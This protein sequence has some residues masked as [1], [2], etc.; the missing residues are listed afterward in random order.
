MEKEQKEG[1]G[2]IVYSAEALRNRFQTN[3]KNKSGRISTTPEIETCAVSD[4]QALIDA[5]KVGYSQQAVVEFTNF[6]QAVKNGTGAENDLSSKNPPL[7][8]TAAVREF[9]EEPEEDSNSLG[10]Y[11]LDKRLLIKA[12]H[13]D[14]HFKPPIYNIWKQQTKTA[15]VGEGV[16]ETPF[17]ETELQGGFKCTH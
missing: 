13:M 8:K 7:A 9:D 2:E 12:D 6:L 4:L 5:A 1:L 17:C 15:G 3:S 14:E 16:P 10:V 11:E